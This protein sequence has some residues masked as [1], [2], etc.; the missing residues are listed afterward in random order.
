MN[1][2]APVHQVDEVLAAFAVA[3]R[4][5]GVP[6]TMDRTA[7]FLRGCAAVG[8]ADR[9]A[10]YWTGR[11]TLCG[12]QE[13]LE[14]YDHVFTAWFAGSGLAPTS[15]REHSRRTA[16]ADLG[17]GYGEGGDPGEE[18]VVRASASRTEVL[19]HRDIAAMSPAERAELGRLLGRLRPRPPLRTSRRRRRS[20]RGEIDARRT[21]RD[22]LRRG[23]EPARLTFRRRT[24]RPRRVVV[25]IDVSGSMG[26]YADSLLRW[27]HVLTRASPGRTEVFTIGTRLTRVSRAMRS[28]DGEAALEAAGQAVPDWSGGTRLGEAMQLFINR[29]GQRGLARGAVVVVV[30]DGWERGD[31]AQLGEQM[32]RLRRLA[33]R[34]VWINPHRGKAGYAP[35]QGGM[36]AALPFVDFFLAGHSMVTFEEALEVI[37]DA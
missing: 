11:A 18:T 2:A 16:Q 17:D 30:S 27:A 8:V 21:L 10:V 37:A 19:R 9:N 1:A 32:Q 29:H 36:V 4:A 26:A 22:Q 15:A 13:D 3:V 6:V 24:T 31:S 5:A 28:R 23:G 14:R 20:R 7:T 35:V 33:H 12:T 25:L 34:V